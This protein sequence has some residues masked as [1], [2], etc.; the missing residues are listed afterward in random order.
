MYVASVH[1]LR[2]S[3]NLI[4]LFIGISAAIIRALLNISHKNPF[5]INIHSIFYNIM[6][7]NQE[8]CAYFVVRRSDRRLA[9]TPD[10]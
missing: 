10:P 5:Y 3:I 9:F 4:I 7:K 8:K 2:Y 1:Y 6:G